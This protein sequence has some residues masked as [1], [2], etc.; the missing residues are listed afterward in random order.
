MFSRSVPELVSIHIPKT[1][2]TSFRNILKAV[3]GD[4]NVAR[5][6]IS[7]RGVVRLN[8]QAFEK[9]RLPSFKVLHGHFSYEAIVSRYKL[10]E[11]VPL[12]TWVRDPVQRVISNYLYL[13]SRLIDIL[14]E[15]KHDLHILEK[16][17]RSLV[18]YARVEINRNRQSKFLKGASL[19]R[20]FFIGITENFER[21][22]RFLG[23]K[24]KWDKQPELLHHNITETN[25]RKFSQEELDEIRSLNMEDVKLYDSILEMRSRR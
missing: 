20:F 3:Y 4:K 25:P 23:E 9:D 18:E 11:E 1:A 21:D 17:Q 24:L 12:I 15:E 2:G 6:D 10:P 13:E 19:D 14:Q 22:L 7:M 5:F 16:M 8:E